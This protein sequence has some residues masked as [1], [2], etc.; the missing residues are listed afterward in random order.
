MQSNN[1]K[2]PENNRPFFKKGSCKMKIEYIAFDGTRFDNP[3]ACEAYENG[4]AFKIFD[5]NGRTLCKNEFDG[6]AA[7]IDVSTPEKLESYDNYYDCPDADD[8]FAAPNLYDP[9]YYIYDSRMDDW[10][11]RSYYEDKLKEIDSIIEKAIAKE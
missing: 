8:D 2:R 4:N 11:E 9:D 7:L 3:S 10:V 5:S 1:Y 6:L